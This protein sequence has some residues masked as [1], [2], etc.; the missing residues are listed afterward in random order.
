MSAAAVSFGKRVCQ[1]LSKGAA[2]L[3]SRSTQ[4]QS[5]SSLGLST[6]SSLTSAP[7]T[8]A[9]TDEKHTM[10]ASSTQSQA[11]SLRL[12]TGTLSPASVSAS[13][14]PAKRT[15]LPDFLPSFAEESK[16]RMYFD[17]GKFHIQCNDLQ[18]AAILKHCNENKVFNSSGEYMSEGSGDRSFL[19]FHK[20]MNFVRFFY[21]CGWMK[22]ENFLQLVGWAEK[23][24]FFETSIRLDIGLALGELRTVFDGKQ[25]KA[26]IFKLS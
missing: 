13:K 3:A 10:T 2:Y 16:I 20:T 15:E 18:R 4:N 14:A 25:Y 12:R 8:S 6:R 21:T 23:K 17:S 11:G 9:A 26:I 22:E 1:F 19:T 24:F 5:S 7:A